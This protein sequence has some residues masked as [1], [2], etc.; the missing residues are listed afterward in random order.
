MRAVAFD[1]LS[2]EHHQALGELRRAAEQLTPVYVPRRAAP[3]PPVRKPPVE[4]RHLWK[5]YREFVAAYAQA[6]VERCTALFERLPAELRG[7]VALLTFLARLGD[8]R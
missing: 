4:R 6:D 5:A 1:I 8:G 3:P 2:A 7:I